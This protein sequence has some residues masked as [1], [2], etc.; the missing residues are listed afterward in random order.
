MTEEMNG[1]EV[2]GIQFAKELVDRRGERIVIDKGD[3]Y[4]TLGKA[5]SF[6]LD[7]SLES[8]KNEGLKPK[9]KRGRLIEQIEEAAK[10]LTPLQLEAGDI[11]ML[12]ERI[13]RSFPQASFVRQVALLLD[14]ATKE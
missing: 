2:K 14:P 7:A 11:D 10:T 4:M 6:A 8:D 1:K 13:A 12:K 5:C 3:D 9:I